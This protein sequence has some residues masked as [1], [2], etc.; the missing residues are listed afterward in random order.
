MIHYL[1]ASIICSSSS[2]HNDA[3]SG[4]GSVINWPHRAEDSGYESEDTKEIF[5]DPQHS[6]HEL[7]HLI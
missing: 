7:E 3:H 6:E 1:F 5:T 4:S 2:E